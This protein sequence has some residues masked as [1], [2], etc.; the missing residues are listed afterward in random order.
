MRVDLFPISCAK[1]SRL[2]S[3]TSKNTNNNK[4]ELSFFPDLVYTR[5]K[6]QKQT[7][8]IIYK[9]KIQRTVSLMIDSW[10]L[11]IFFDRYRPRLK[12]LAFNLGLRKVSYSPRFY[13]QR[14]KS[15][16]DN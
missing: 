1:K 9:L 7:F 2:R 11:N 3:L 12:A 8:L 10:G 16:R 6:F 15:N 13:Q 14:I 4:A 5:K